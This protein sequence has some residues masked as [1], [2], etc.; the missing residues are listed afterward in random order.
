ML[1][2]LHDCCF[3]ILRGLASS[4]N[5]NWIIIIFFFLSK[6]PIGFSSIPIYTN[7]QMG[8]CF[9]MKIVLLVRIKNLKLQ[10]RWQLA[11]N[12]ERKKRWSSQYL[13]T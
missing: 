3:F 8:P 7:D 13:N 11:Y 1:L 2:E 6:S 12:K 10:N 5:R 4:Q 9:F